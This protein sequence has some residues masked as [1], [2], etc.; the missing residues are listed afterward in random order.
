MAFVVIAAAYPAPH[1]L[2][3]SLAGRGVLTSNLDQ[4]TRV[5][6]SPSPLTP[7]M[8]P[9]ADSDSPEEDSPDGIGKG[10]ELDQLN[11]LVDLPVYI[12]FEV[13]VNVPVGLRLDSDLSDADSN[14]PESR[15][16]GAPGA[17]DSPNT[18]NKRTELD[19]TARSAPTGADESS[20]REEMSKVP[21][22]SLPESQHHAS[23]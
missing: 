2:T 16:L 8:M 23:N 13:P 14:G 11:V 10:A 20:K 12:P 19:Y 6:G 21:I 18:P 3:A 17:P 22:R 9:S 1:L 7:L 4:N 5:V 15:D